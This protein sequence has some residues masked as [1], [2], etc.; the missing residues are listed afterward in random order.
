MVKDSISNLIIG[1]KN[2]STAGKDS[3]TV[4]FSNMSLAILELL[5]K[6]GFINDVTIDKT[7]KVKK[8]ITAELKYEGGTPAIHGVKRISHLSKRV[9]KSTKEI[10]PVKSGYGRL[11][12][13]TPKGIVT[14]EFARENSVGG[15][16]LFEIW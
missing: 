2:A 9:Y 15:E 14:D 3:I 6:E 12:L 16:A 13:T 1:L 10:K 7:D 8:Q 5:K 4:D 11:I